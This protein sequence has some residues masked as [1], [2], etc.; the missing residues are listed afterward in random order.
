MFFF[1]ANQAQQR[2]KRSEFENKNLQEQKNLSFEKDFHEGT[3][4]VVY[5]TNHF[6]AC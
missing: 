6:G 5:M 1:L 4:V 3:W 2:G